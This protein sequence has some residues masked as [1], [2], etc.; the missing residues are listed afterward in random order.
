MMFSHLFRKIS[1]IC[2][3]VS[4]CVLL[5][6]ISWVSAAT[7]PFAGDLS[8]GQTSDDVILLQKI[9]NADRDTQVAE[10]GPGS[11]GNETRY[12]GRATRN[13]VIRFQNKYARDILIPAGLVRG[14]GYVGVRTRQKMQLL[15]TPTQLPKNQDDM[16]PKTDATDAIA[17]YFGFQ[18]R[19][20]LSVLRIVG[21]SSEVVR[22]GD[23]LTLFGSGFD[24]TSNT[25]HFGELVT[26]QAAAQ[27][28]SKLSFQIPDS[29]PPGKYS[30][31]VSHSQGTTDSSRVIVVLDRDVQ[32]TPPKITFLSPE[33]GRIGTEIVITGENFSAL[34]DIRTTYAYFPNV[35]SLDGKTI[36]FTY[37]KPEFAN[38]QAMKTAGKKVADLDI[39]F[40]VTIVNANGVSSQGK[41]F[42]LQI[43]K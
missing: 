23:T 41:K 38:L 11:L 34:N 5:F 40:Y 22:K 31:K 24:T 19:E 17:A 3:F 20:S 30:L 18:F 25:I 29:V 2:L 39:P 9:L 43:R 14:T 1:L 35:P 15:S 6:P 37:T 36:R 26:V 42:T 16:K 28:T 7:G 32:L 27:S 13:A 8:F 12:F 21:Q 10:S 33:V 4:G